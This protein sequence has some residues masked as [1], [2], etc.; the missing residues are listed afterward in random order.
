MTEDTTKELR[1]L[2]GKA[3][4]F[5]EF[6]PDKGAISVKLQALALQVELMY[7]ALKNAD[8]HVGTCPLNRLDAAIEALEFAGQNYN[9]RFRAFAEVYALI[10]DNVAGVPL[11]P[12]WKD[13]AKL[14]HDGVDGVGKIARRGGGR[15][16]RD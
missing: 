4:L 14:Y 9:E 3:R 6:P 13:Y 15:G 10:R 16:P 2:S 1:L 5:D 12:H 8:A 7:Q 11:L